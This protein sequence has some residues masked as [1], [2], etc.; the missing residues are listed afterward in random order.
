M[1][2]TDD[3]N[4]LKRLRLDCRLSVED[5][6]RQLGIKVSIIYRWEKGVRHPSRQS[7]LELARLYKVGLD[8]IIKQDI[9]PTD[10]DS[11][12]AGNNSAYKRLRDGGLNTPYCDSQCSVANNPKHL[13]ASTNIPIHHHLKRMDQAGSAA[14][15]EKVIKEVITNYGFNYF[16]YQQMYRDDIGENPEITTLSN[17]PNEWTEHYYKKGYGA[18]D[19]TWNYSLHNTFPILSDELV[20]ISSNFGRNSNR[21]NKRL[22]QGFFDDL[23]SQI[24]PL[25][26]TIPIHGKICNATLI[27]SVAK[28]TRANRTLLRNSLAN[29]LLMGS[30]IYQRMQL[31]AH[32]NAPFLK[33]KEIE[34]IKGLAIGLSTRAIA[35]ELSLSTQRINQIIAIARKKLD[36][37]TRDQL[38]SISANA[39]IIPHNFA[40]MR[41]KKDKKIKKRE[42][43]KME[44]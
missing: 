37:K 38:V 32:S 26:Y 27:V 43:A 12:G 29:M 21:K 15:L 7:A 34:V 4:Y 9:E 1:S 35:A 22:T 30:K 19:P 42:K 6:A 16:Y 18:V 36:A 41:I 23:K 25:Y 10:S 13:N 28:D 44:T 20:E 17:L 8:E 2:N 39:G 5:V 33:P 11:S 40:Q 3:I 31:L 14:R 24:C